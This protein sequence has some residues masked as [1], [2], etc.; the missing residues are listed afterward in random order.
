VRDQEV[1]FRDK[2]GEVAIIQI[3]AE[4]LELQGEKCLLTVGQDVTERKR[5]AEDL[6]KLSGQLLRSQ[7]DERRRIAQNLHDSTGQNLV[8]LATMIGQ[9]SR[10]SRLDQRKKRRLLIESKAL[11]DQCICEVRT[12]SYS[13]YPAVLDGIGLAGAITDYVNGFCKRSGIQVNLKLPSN[14]GQLER[15]IE[16]ALLRVVQEAL[17]N[18]QR[19][20]GSQKA[21]IRIERDAILALEISD[22]GCGIIATRRKNNG[23][24]LEFGV[25]ISSMQERI[26]LIGGSLRIDSSDRGTKVFVTVP[27]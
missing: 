5:A 14:L 22:S 23:T 11:A 1:K 8:A 20:S 17:T 10:P 6:R 19:H 24:R 4:L 26:R 2:T 7:D 25:G 3:S 13:L 9:L 12:L 16:L 18:I 15:G 21:T 27:V